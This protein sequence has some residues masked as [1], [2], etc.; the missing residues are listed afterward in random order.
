MGPHHLS[1]PL[2]RE[3]GLPYFS[4]V[5]GKYEEDDCEEL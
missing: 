3:E 5:K 4:F 2:P 1:I